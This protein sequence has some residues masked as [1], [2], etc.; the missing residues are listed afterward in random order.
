MKHLITKQLVRVA[1]ACVVFTGCSE[2]G[3]SPVPSKSSLGSDVK[4]A[5]AAAAPTAEAPAPAAEPAPVAVAEADSGTS[6]AA[7]AAD[8]APAPQDMTAEKPPAED[9]AVTQLINDCGGAKI[10]KAAPTETIF[11][12]NMKAIGFTAPPQFGVTAHLGASLS[13]SATPSKTTEEVKVDVKSL[14]GFFALFGVGEAKD[15]AAKNSGTMTYTSVAFNALPQLGDHNPDWRGIACSVLASTGLDSHMGKNTTTVTFD[16]PLPTSVQPA[17]AQSRIET[18]IGDKKVFS[19]IKASIVKTNHPLLKNLTSVTG[20]V[21]ITKVS[22]KVTV[23]EDNG[24]VHNI[25]AE[26]AYLMTFDFKSPAITNA[27][28]MIPS[29]TL[30]LKN[31]TRTMV[32]NTADTSA[33]GGAKVT[34][35]AP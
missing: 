2:P 11:S 25:S 28:G 10:I 19:N 9:P 15:E 12:E 14:D 16:P 30:Y 8:P 18:E 7:T 31:S 6:G 24:T 3:K 4:T 35:L 13:I 32:A 20:T 27:L 26:S 22:P 23:K 5:P 17:A 34:F 33:V 29:V 21:T 1:A